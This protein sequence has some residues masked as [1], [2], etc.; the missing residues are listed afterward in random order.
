MRAKPA[1]GRAEALLRIS[2][3]HQFRAGDVARTF[4]EYP[5]LLFDMVGTKE[6]RKSQK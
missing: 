6:R 1:A 4:D 3:K 5:V 2:D